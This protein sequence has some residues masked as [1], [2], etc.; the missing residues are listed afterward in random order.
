MKKLLVGIV[1]LFIIL[2][3]TNA[4]FIFKNKSD[5]NISVAIK[6]CANTVTNHWITYGWY[7]I[8]SGNSQKVITTP[9]NNRYFYFFAQS[10]DGEYIWQGTY[11]TCVDSEKFQYDDFPTGGGYSNT[12]CPSVMKFQMVDVGNYK[13]YTY[14]LNNP[15]SK[16]SDFFEPPPL[17]NEIPPW[18]KEPSKKKSNPTNETEDKPKIK[19][20][21]DYVR[22][23]Y[24]SVGANSC[25]A[26][27]TNLNQTRTIIVDVYTKLDNTLYQRERVE[28]FG[29]T[30]VTASMC[31]DACSICP[32]TLYIKSAKFL[33]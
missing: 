7:Q 14:T 20:A 24:V 17:N 8:S 3:S 2:N 31:F 28:P 21:R 1:Y 19:N 9:L 27:L 11:E 12:L 30:Y 29:K 22:L 13:S 32:Q 25:G 33:D 23:D 6:Y 15:N 26:Q 10:H 16:G 18:M 4:Q 5:K